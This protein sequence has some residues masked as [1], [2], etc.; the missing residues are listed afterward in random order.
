MDESITEPLL[1]VGKCDG[2][3]VAP[4]GDKNFGWDPIF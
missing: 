2:T 1:F 3:I 4:R